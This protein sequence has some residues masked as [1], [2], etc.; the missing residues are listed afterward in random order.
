MVTCPKCNSENVAAIPI[1]G[2]KKLVVIFIPRIP[3]LCLDCKRHFGCF[4]NPLKNTTF[5]IVLGIIIIASISSLILQQAGK[6]STRTVVSVN[7]SMP[8]PMPK[9]DDSKIFK[10]KPLDKKIDKKLQDSTELTDRV[11]MAEEGKA[12]QTDS[13]AGSAIIVQSETTPNVKKELIKEDKDSEWEIADSGEKDQLKKVLSDEIKQESEDKTKVIFS[14]QK[15]ASILEK[16][17]EP[18]EK[19]E[20]SIKESNLAAAETSVVEAF[21][22]QKKKETLPDKNKINIVEKAEAETIV[23]KLYGV[24]LNFS[25]GELQMKINADSPIKDYKYFILTKPARLVIDLIGNWEKP[26]FFAKETVNSQI[27]RI[28]LWRHSDKLRIVCDL[29]KNDTIS[30]IFE[31]SSNGLIIIIKDRGHID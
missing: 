6:T 28:R 14:E 17:D 27:S 26:R 25:E 19:E 21:E 5:L 9:A 15:E 30:P 10:I 1:K 11:D 12:S 8:M 29:K 4:A 22:P 3:Y 18:D 20:K 24:E 16:K 7:K 2:M 31:E 23:H 13:F